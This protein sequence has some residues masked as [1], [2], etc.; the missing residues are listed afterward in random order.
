M[1]PTRTRP[2]PS[3]SVS[4]PYYGTN[5]TALVSTV[6]KVVFNGTEW[7]IVLLKNRT[8][9]VRFLIASLS[10]S[11]GLPAER[12]RI[13]SL[14]I[15]SLI[16]VIEILRNGSQALPE[17]FIMEAVQNG[18]DFLNVTTLYRN[19]SGDVFGGALGTVAAIAIDGAS[20]LGAVCD[21]DCLMG[22]GIA[23]GISVFFAVM[24]VL[25][26]YVTGHCGDHEDDHVSGCSESAEEDLRFED[27][28]HLENVF[29]DAYYSHDECSS[30]G[31]SSYDQWREL[32]SL[33]NNCHQR[34]LEFLPFPYASHDE[35][36]FKGTMGA[37]GV[38][39]DDVSGPYSPASPS[40]MR[41]RTPSEISLYDT[42]ASGD[43]ERTEDIPR[44]SGYES[45]WGTASS[46]SISLQPR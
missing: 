11:L 43:G 10:Q 41:S 23:V 24:V 8:A 37:D 15:G 4:E 38:E 22:V 12:V 19:V 17:A 32:E 29:S 30:S 27:D 28:L 25:L 5:P 36:D 45:S 16:A 33:H 39:E 6:T 9:I 14:T 46:R 13:V 21:E 31:G 26:F 18:T 35:R 2:S 40:S 3:L 42:W 7:A 20:A 1:T 44:S 34:R